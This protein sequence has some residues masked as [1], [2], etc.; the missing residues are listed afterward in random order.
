MQVRDM[1]MDMA[2]KLTGGDQLETIR[3]A[4]LNARVSLAAVQVWQ[5]VM[6]FGVSTMGSMSLLT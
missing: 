1:E 6:C 5:G 4:E 3:S 2:I